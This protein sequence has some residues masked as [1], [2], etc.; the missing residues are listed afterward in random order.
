MGL[1]VE[2]TEAEMGDGCSQNTGKKHLRGTLY[3]WV[4]LCNLRFCIGR[5]VSCRRPP[6]TG[7]LSPFYSLP[8]S[9]WK[10]APGSQMQVAARFGS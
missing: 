7:A 2:V 9:G 3:T 10:V 5:S 1:L 8:R 6:Q 4:F